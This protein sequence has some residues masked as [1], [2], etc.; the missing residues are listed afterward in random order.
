MFHIAFT[1]AYLFL[2]WRFVLP[3][4]ISRNWRLLIAVLLFVVSKVH[5][6]NDVLYGNMWS[7]E[8]PYS[9]AVFLGWAFCAFVLLFIFVLIGDC[10]WLL[11]WFVRR[12]RPRNRLPSWLSSVAPILAASA[13]L[14]GVQ[15]AVGV[16]EVK[17]IELPIV[18]LPASLDGFKLV[19]LTD[20]HI[21]RLFPEEWVQKVVARTN[22]LSPDLILFTGDFIDGTVGERV[23]D[24]APLA[25]LKARFGVLGIPGNHEYYFDY[26][27]WRECL[28][29]LGIQLIENSH[30]QLQVQDAGLTIVGV[31]DAAARDYGFAGPD[32]DVALRGAS[33]KW[34]IVLMSHRPE[35][36]REYS[37]A[38]VTLQLSG[39]T[40]G[41][42]MVGL[43]QLGKFANQGFTSGLYDI[44]AMKLYVSNGTALWMGFPIRLGVPSEITLFTLRA[45]ARKRDVNDVDKN[46][47]EI[48]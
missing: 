44:D 40:H 45:A 20:T 14:V 42:M 30:V 46:L 11:V 1:L 22:A 29:G 9:I 23:A 17:H 34:P 47:R 24:V 39:H 28:S 8:V 2:L 10:L 15:N 25:N 7:F 5:W 19:Q 36:A 37:K 13:S 16:P 43:N 12:R 48:D 32:L 3:L 27:Q 33:E 18:G 21:S 38:G 41:G 26:K 35:G 6:I 4:P 31:T